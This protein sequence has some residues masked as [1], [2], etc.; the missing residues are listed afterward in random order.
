MVPISGSNSPEPVARGKNETAERF[1]L[2]DQR[3]N[4]AAAPYERPI[5]AN[6]A[7]LSA[8][9]INRPRLASPAQSVISVN[10]NEDVVVPKR[11]VR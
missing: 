3:Q 7:R 10:R 5:A 4:A 9:A 6:I 1:C 11:T 8:I 2:A